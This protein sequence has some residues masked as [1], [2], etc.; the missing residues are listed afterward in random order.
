MNGLVV[1]KLGKKKGEKRVGGGQGAVNTR[2]PAGTKRERNS[3]CGVCTLTLVE[4]YPPPLVEEI[5]YLHV[6]EKRLIVS[7]RE[8]CRGLG[9][10]SSS[11]RRA[12]L[13]PVC[14]VTKLYLTPGVLNAGSFPRQSL[15]TPLDFRG[16]G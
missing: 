16:H 3:V 4:G 8:Q 12:L 6:V 9:R 7:E 13:W 10:E 1:F 14:S 5:H 2:I 15:L 11:Q